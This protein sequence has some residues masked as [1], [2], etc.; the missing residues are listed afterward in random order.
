[1][2]GPEAAEDLFKEEDP[3][4]RMVMVRGQPFR[5]LGVMRQLGGNDSDFDDTVW[6]P[7]TT[8]MDRLYNL[9]Y[10]HR[11]EVQAVDQE[12]LAAAEHQIAGVLRERHRIAPG[13]DDDFI[14]RN[15]L[16]LLETA[17]ETSQTF[18]Y[19]LAGIACISLLVGGIGIMNIMLVSVAE[20]TREIGIRR[21]VGARRNDI[22]VQFLTEA[23]VMCG[24]G[25]VLGVAVGIGSCWGGEAYAGWPMLPTAPAVLISCVT[26]VVVGLIFGIYPAVRASGLSPME[27]LRC[28]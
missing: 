9:D 26:A 14:I 7:V 20:R 12:R 1:M 3:V 2:L 5:V 22:L 8:A 4:D 17:S 21:A 6:I 24:L 25:A 18:T 28:E 15:Q 11:I 16:N 10:I 27:A 23:V 19:L 13:R